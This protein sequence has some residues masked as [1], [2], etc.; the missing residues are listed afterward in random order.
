MTGKVI[1]M[2]DKDYYINDRLPIIS[3][4]ITLFME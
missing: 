1:R 4:A 3:A 2:I